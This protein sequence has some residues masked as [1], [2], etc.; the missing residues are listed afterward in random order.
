MTALVQARGTAAPDVD[1]W[2]PSRAGL[3]ALWR[4]W[5]ET[6]TFH[7][8]RLLL[9]G[10]NGSGKSMALE[11]LLPYLLDADSS[12]HRLTSAAKSRGGL[13]ERIMTGSEDS[14]R[15]GFA[16]V[17]FV[18]GDDVLT[19]GVR[20]R[21]S[22]ATRKVDSAYFTTTQRIGTD[23]Q[24]LGPDRV[25]LS[26]RELE[27]AIGG[28]GRVHATAEEYRTTL[29][30]TLFPGFGAD[31]Y[32]SVLTALL[33]LRKEK[34]S[35]NLDLVKLSEVLSEA[36][37]PVDEH[38]LAAVAEGFE[39]LDRRQAELARLE[40]ELREVRQ[41]RSRQRTY[42]RAVLRRLTG[43][44]RAAETRHGDVRRAERE[45]GEA[46]QHARR[47]ATDLTHES[48]SV[49]VRLAAIGVEREALRD[50]DAYREGSGLRDLRDQVR[51]LAAAAE[52][53]RRSLERR[54]RTRAEAEE[55]DR[56]AVA[57]RSE[58]TRD[59]GQAWDDVERT[60][61][62]IGAG[63]VAVE[64]RGSVQVEPGVP[65]TAEQALGLLDAWLE[66]RR[67]L[68][69]EV[70]AALE[71][72]RG[73]VRARDFAAER[74]EDDQGVLDDRVRD[75]QDARGALAAAVETFRAEVATWVAS[76]R[77]LDPARVVA[78]LP[79][80]AEVPDE[81]D[82]AVRA[83]GADLRAEHTAALRAL[84]ARRDE[85]AT[86]R[87]ELQAERDAYA[88]G[89]V[90]EPVPPAWRAERTDRAGAPLWRLVEVGEDVA[91]GVVDG[92]ES[93]LTGAGLID[94]WVHPDGRVEPLEH[95][96]DLA[97]GPRPVAG[98]TLADV[99]TA[100][101]HPEVPPEVVAA[102]LGSIP[103]L[104][105]V[106]A[107][108]PTAT[109][110]EHTRES[111]GELV[112]AED[113]TFRIGPAVG[114]GPVGAAVLLGA[115]ARER[116]RVQRLAELD[117]QL[118]EVDRQLGAL[119]REAADRRRT[120]EAVAAELGA[121]PHGQ[122][123]G[124]AGTALTAAGSRTA[125][126]ADAVQRSR[127]RREAAERA[128][129]EALRTLT[130]AGALHG[131][132]TDA[133]AL[134]LV[135]EGLAALRQQAA[136]WSLRVQDVRRATAQQIEAGGRLRRAEEEAEETAEDLRVAEQDH[137]DVRV[138]LARLETSVG[139][140]FAEILTALD[141]LQTEQTAQDARRRVLAEE[142]PR[143]AAQRG[144][145]EAQLAQ[146]EQ[147]R[148][149]AVEHREESQ[150]R[151]VGCLRDGLAV[152]ADLTAPGS[153][154]GV[155]AVLQA[156]RE[157][158]AE[159]GALSDPREEERSSQLLTERLHTA[160][161]LVGGRSDLERRLTSD[162]WWV[163]SALV[164]G[165]RRSITDLVGALAGELEAGRQEFAE[166]EEQLFEQVL[167]G[168]VR[169]AL[170]ARIRLA[171]TL[172]D[173][174]NTQLD[175]VRTVAGGVAVRLRWDVDPDQLAAVRS[176]RAL[177]LRDPHDLT[178]DESAALQDFVRARVEQA[179]AELE[180]SAPWEA[181]LRET[182][183][184]RTWHRF[185]LLVAHRDWDGYQAATASRLQ[186]LSTG[187]RSIALH[188]PMMASLAAH[189]ADAEGNP[190]GCPRLVLLD[191]LF[192]G[193]DPAN[194]AQLFGTFTTWDLD[195]LF[196]SD[197]EWCQYASLDGIA[198]HHLHPPTGDEPV[199]STRF[200]WD[201]RQRQVDP[202]P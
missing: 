21:T 99:L 51:R 149:A 188:L 151:L 103:V 69:R 133:T 168:S 9:R 135:E 90:V 15:T 34:L 189:Y 23:L 42:A 36:L 20:L 85:T 185:T 78:V 139:A 181:R 101:P 104:P 172:V 165:L 8:G 55:T 79:A 3:V 80:P 95:P 108:L 60:A 157:L 50:S 187:E 105:T 56:R 98:P 129:R 45:A 169:R 109:S 97:L 16:W 140:E 4:Y 119:D 148:V 177:L 117:R 175:R 183:D 126:A 138:R 24:L 46:L 92:L 77:A 91:P 115:E 160:R 163:L 143:V 176:A 193:V 67:Q 29:R 136:T 131:L 167:A 191:E 194:R 171:N 201:G 127:G 190:S 142:I 89:Q 199:T 25:P 13:F 61:E 49:E 62:R 174:I 141:Q 134:D 158:G 37:A 12:P 132:P 81:V 162:D 72:Y 1:R 202:S 66:S 75:E 74:L 68:L 39:R 164:A 33:A 64:A 170:A 173:G 179:R 54:R 124:R 2:R 137:T 180:P 18:R 102:V 112:L 155:T 122:A 107:R 88:A 152:D 118:D 178:E 144:A 38:D 82:R 123:V 110:R 156:S 94:A 197:H 84:A 153:P 28:R 17:E 192:A 10:P 130:T 35:Q 57:A 41:L 32:A 196:T 59:E 150:R 30:T 76:L 195:A 147:S 87:E 58:A 198:I 14:S 19:A 121:L 145:L 63:A 96:G 71:T 106:A 65:A 47:A 116:R 128:T 113:G 6:F 120:Y 186:R 159:L 200:V 31:R 166:E 73:A 52:V 26:R 125:Q 70:R 83:L 93:A 182:L 114:R 27:A 7:H 184:Y 40:A 111:P 48:A 22:Q 43:E 100:L 5:D 11:L 161:E 53:A 44:V 86:R 146:V 154:E